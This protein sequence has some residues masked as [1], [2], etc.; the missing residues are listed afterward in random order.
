[1]Q[2]IHLEMIKNGQFYAITFRK[3][4]AAGPS[5]SGSTSSVASV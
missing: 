3:P 1:M 2:D 4:P 5:A